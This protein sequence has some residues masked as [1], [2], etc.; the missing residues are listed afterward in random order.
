MRGHQSLPH[1]AGFTARRLGQQPGAHTEGRHVT[2]H[3]RLRQDDL[4]AGLGRA[5]EQQVDQTLDEQVVGARRRDPHE[6]HADL[7]RGL[8]RLGVEVVDDLHVVGDE[9]DRCDDDRA[10]PT[11]GGE[12]PRCG[13]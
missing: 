8:G 1:R 6:R 7:L 4:A 2:G 11:L 12:A 5:L 3:P 13:R 9:P 10:D